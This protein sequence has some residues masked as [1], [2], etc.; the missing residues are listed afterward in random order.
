MHD[1]A[2]CRVECWGVEVYQLWH[3]HSVLVLLYS[4]HSTGLNL[5]HDD[6]EMLRG[7]G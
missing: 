1:A 6:L 7:C 4:Q 5:Q 2:V 3:M